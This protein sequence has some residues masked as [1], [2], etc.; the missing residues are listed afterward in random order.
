MESPF[1]NLK[2]PLLETERLFLVPWSAEF[3]HDLLDFASNPAVALP[4][5][6]KIHTSRAQAERTVARLASANRF[7]W[8]LVPK[9]GFSR[10]LPRAVGG[11][12]LY[13]AKLRGFTRA[14]GVGYLLAEEFWGMGLCAEAV[15]KIAH[16]VFLGL[17]A[18]ALCASH[19]VENP[20]SGR[21]IEKCGFTRYGLCPKDKP[22]APRTKLLYAMTRE[23]FAAK[24]G[25]GE[26]VFGLDVYRVKTRPEP[27]AVDSEKINYIAQPHA[28]QCGQAC[29]A[30][31]AG[32]STAE[33]AWAMN[34]DFGTSDED[35]AKGLDY[36]GIPHAN[37]RKPCFS[38]GE[39][40]EL[41]IIS[42]ALPGYGHWSLYARGK[43]YDP[44]F[45]VS[46][47]LPDGARLCYDWK[48]G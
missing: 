39:L 4:A 19:R 23:E 2:P 35:V 34:E 22:D 43:F 3:A 5:D 38:P 11:I 9:D 36:Y 30:M 20:R 6:W 17:D 15:R 42:L 27:R 41:C 33:A 14:F 1:D 44:E 45:G 25:Y 26:E 47:R 16:Y 40:P 18:D 10:G 48:I 29:V 31:L 12:G 8:A 32:V 13:P 37:L 7:E 46:D 21:V 28:Y 24:S